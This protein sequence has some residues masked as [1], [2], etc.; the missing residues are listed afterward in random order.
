MD[1]LKLHMAPNPMERSTKDKKIIEEQDVSFAPFNRSENKEIIN[2][3]EIMMYLQNTVS[4]HLISLDL[5]AMVP[6]DEP[7]INNFN[8]I[9]FLNFI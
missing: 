8:K 7:D 1:L 6:K 3:F 2:I 5:N 9:S 4:I